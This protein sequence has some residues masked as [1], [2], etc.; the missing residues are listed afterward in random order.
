ME[1]LITD[2][3]RIHSYDSI[4]RGYFYIGFINFMWKM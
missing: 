1:I 3:Y 4:M 2:I